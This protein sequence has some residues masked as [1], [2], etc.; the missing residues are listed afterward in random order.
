M[1]QNSKMIS[2]TSYKNSYKNFFM[3]AYNLSDRL[4]K[5]SNIVE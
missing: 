2:I 5:S 4:I 3:Y 1:N